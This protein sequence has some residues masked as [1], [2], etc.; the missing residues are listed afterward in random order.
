MVI[1]EDKRSALMFEMDCDSVVDFLQG[2]LIMQSFLVVR[3]FELDSACSS[4]SDLA[5]PHSPGEA[6]ECCLVILAVYREDIGSFPLVLHGH[7]DETTISSVSS[8]PLPVALERCLENVRHDQKALKE[9]LIE[10]KS[11]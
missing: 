3:N 9:K 7:G 1:M 10:G 4:L 5:C 11:V 6:C 8:Q 2:W